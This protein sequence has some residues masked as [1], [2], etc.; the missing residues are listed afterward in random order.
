MSQKNVQFSDF[1]AVDLATLPLSPTGAPMYIFNA[2]R[3]GTVRI[4]CSFAVATLEQLQVAVLEE[5]VD[6][7]STKIPYAQ[8]AT[9]VDGVF[10]SGSIVV[11]VLAPLQYTIVGLDEQSLP[12]TS[13]VLGVTYL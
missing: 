4:D 2:K 11:S 9:A 13:G 6:G 7:T 3:S 8:I 5:E 12:I 10:L 1:T